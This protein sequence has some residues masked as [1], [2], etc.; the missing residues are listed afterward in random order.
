MTKK[1]LFAPFI[2]CLFVIQSYM[3]AATITTKSPLSVVYVPEKLK[4]SIDLICDITAPQDLPASLQNF[5]FILEQDSKIS[6]RNVIK[7]VVEDARATLE[8]SQ[9]KF[10]EKSH[11]LIIS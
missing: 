5:F 9:H 4:A 8:K 10:I 2:L 6:S 7:K 1:L 3:Y 11:F